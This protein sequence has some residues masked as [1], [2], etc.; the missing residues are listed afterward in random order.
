MRQVNQRRSCPRDRRAP[1]IAVATV[2]LGA[3]AAGCSSSA[4]PEQPAVRVSVLVEGSWRVPD[5]LIEAFEGQAD[6][7]LVIRKAGPDAGALADRLVRGKSEPLGDVAFGLYSA[8]VRRAL[9]A[10]VFE[11]YT[12]PEANKGPQ[13]Y[14]VDK[15]QRVSAVD[16][17]DVCVNV[18]TEW[19]ADAELDPPETFADLVDPRYRN[20]LVVP[21]PVYSEEGA[22][23]L[24]GTIAHHGTNGWRPY[25]SKLKANGARVVDTS[26]QAYHEEFTAGDGAGRRPM[27]VSSALSP[28]T[29][30]GER[31]PPTV[32]VP[33]TCYRRVRYAGVLAGTEHPARAGQV[34]DFLLSQQFQESLAENLGTYPVRERVLLPEGWDK[35]APQP[36]DPLT[37]PG[38]E[39]RD[40]QERWLAEWRALMAR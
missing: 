37:L 23:F 40:N 16:V 7:D 39:V 29:E 32:A 13:R 31:N 27:V 9:D 28:A 5:A 15:R 34:V 17:A 12:S 19:F 36:T 18:D 24:L 11:P 14:A 38:D 25:W 26:A 2:L 6:V 22:A 20:L 3:T 30:A 1:L 4:A 33:D 35:V 10:G 8:D 21:S